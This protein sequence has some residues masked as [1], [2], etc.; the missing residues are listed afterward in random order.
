LSSQS[1]RTAPAALPVPARLGA[2]RPRTLVELVIVIGALALPFATSDVYTEFVLTTI[3]IYILVAIGLNLLLG[4]GGQASIAQGALVAMG[5]YAV[6][7]LTVDYGWSFWNSALV[8]IIL[9]VSVSM[10]VALPSFRISH[11]HF[12]LVSLTFAVAVQGAIIQFRDLTHGFTGVVGI[13]YATIGGEDLTG[14]WF[15]LVVIVIDIVAFL[16]VRSIVRSRLGRGLATI[17]DAELV[18]RSSGINVVGLKLF[19]FGVSAVLAGMAGA[20][21]AAHNGVINPTEFDTNLSVLF[22]VVVVVG[23][24]G[25]EWAAIIGTIVFVGAP[26][27]LTFLDDWRSLVYGVVLLAVMVFAPDGIGGLAERLWHQAVASIRKRGSAA[28]RPVAMTD[29]GGQSDDEPLS[30]AVRVTLVNAPEHAG[31]ALTVRSAT[32]RFGGVVALDDVSLDVAPGTV[33]AIVGPNGSGKTTLLNLVSGFY[34]LDAGTIALDGRDITRSSPSAR[35]RAGIG[36]TFQTPRVI[37][38]LSALDNVMVGSSALKDSTAPEL[39]LRLPR[40]WREERRRRE[41][42]RELL[43]FVGLAHRADV[44]AVDLPHGQQRLLEIARALAASPRM[45]LLDEPAAG[46]SL[47]ELDRLGELIGALRATRLTVIVVEH[48]IDLVREAADAVTVLDRGL[49]IALGSPAEVFALPAV[50][51]SYL[52]VQA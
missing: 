40:A 10:F 49:T 1:T 39:I 42:A 33:H 46:L 29:A 13:P 52:G 35:A 22:L 31:V 36:R 19:A 26:E 21:Y 43:A 8:G 25:R 24:A 38:T 28:G 41:Q 47:G 5:A 37:R 50:R 34:R 6:G 7:I 4:Y 9:A 27:L 23:G 44:K 11:W 51:A 32:R 15:L 18:A 17:R 14:H 48:H 2:V 16:L 12:A 3:F 45:L 20:L 30:P